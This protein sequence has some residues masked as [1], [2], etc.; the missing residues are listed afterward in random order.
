MNTYATWDVVNVG[1]S[2]IV[3][4]AVSQ[5]EAARLCGMTVATFRSRSRTESA[6]PITEQ[7]REMTLAEPGVMFYCES[8]V[9]PAPFRAA[10]GF[11][12]AMQD[13]HRW[14][15]EKQAKRVAW[16]TGQIE[17]RRAD[18][19]ALA[20]ARAGDFAEQDAERQRW[21]DQRQ[22]EAEADRAAREMLADHADM[23]ED[24]GLADLR[25]NGDGNITL[26]VEALIGVIRRL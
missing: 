2:R 18:R 17:K 10:A 13:Y 21:R 8:A 25:T 23:L 11:S 6:Y 1:P 12:R 9:A 24:L 20:K 26:P 4:A 7:E 5:P 19:V 16:R 3:I 15:P 22:R 14:D